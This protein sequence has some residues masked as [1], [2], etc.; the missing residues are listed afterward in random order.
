MLIPRIITAVILLLVMLAALFY[1]PPVLWA[2]FSA[3]MVGVALWEFCTMARMQPAAKWSYLLA[4]A[5]LAVAAGW[6]HYTPGIIEQVAVLIFWLALVPLWLVKRWTLNEGLLARFAGWM[7]VFPAWFALLQWRPSSKE[8]TSML[9]IMGIVWVA[10]IA[11]YVA[12]KKFGKHK[13]APAISPGKTWEGVAGGMI[14]CIAYAVLVDQLGWWPVVLPVWW[15]VALAMLFCAVSVAGDLLESWFK[16]G[17]QMKDSSH[18]LPGHG[19]VYD[20]IDGLVA[21]LSV[22]AA[23]YMVILY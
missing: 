6:L 4:S 13:L 21:V 18:L 23:L 2:V 9:A 20:R 15:L 11:A 17:A 3:L 10:D 1:F 16:R 12:G 19:G 7:I 22:S 5:A 8:A 14:G